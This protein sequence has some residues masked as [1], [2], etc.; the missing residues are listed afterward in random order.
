MEGSERISGTVHT[1]GIQSRVRQKTSAPL[2]FVSQSA[3]N[4][5]LCVPGTVG[6]LICRAGFTS[7]TSIP[8]NTVRINFHWTRLYFHNN[9]TIN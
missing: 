1:P 2:V 7:S 4:V 9:G 6:A 8:G 5:S 3:F